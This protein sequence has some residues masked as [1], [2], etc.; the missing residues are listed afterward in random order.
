MDRIWGIWGSYYKPPKAIFYL[1][2]GTIGF[3]VFCLGVHSLVLR[4]Q[5]ED[6]V[7][8]RVRMCH[9]YEVGTPTISD[10]LGF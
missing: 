9:S 10:S 8:Q 6:Q 7:A 3:R 1:L 4:V 5:G 2:R